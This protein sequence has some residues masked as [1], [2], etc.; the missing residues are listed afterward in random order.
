MTNIVKPKTYVFGIPRMSN[1][2]LWITQMKL[3]L[4]AVRRFSAI[5]VTGACLLMNSSESS[6]QPAGY[7]YDE[8]KVPA[9]EL[10]EIL[11]AN[12]GSAITDADVWKSVRRPEILELFAE[13]VFGTLPPDVPQLRTRLRSRTDAAIEGT[14]VRR[15]ITVYFS[16]D[17][18]GPQMDILVYTPANADGPVPCFLGLNFNGNQT[19]EDDPAIRLTTSWIRADRNKTG[20]PNVASEDSRGKSSS[21]WP[22]KDIVARGY[23][24]A[25]VYCGDIDPDFD[26]GFKN[27]IHSLW[28]ADQQGDRAG[29]AGGTIS[30]WSW[31]LSRALDI[32]ETDPLVDGTRVAV[33]GHSRLGKT[34]LWAGATDER[35]KLVISNNS[36]C[37]G[38][39][40][41]RRRFGETVKRI[42][43]SFPHWFCRNHRQ[44]NDNEDQLPVDHHMLMALVAPRAVYVAS[45]E[46]DTWADPKG[47]MLSLYHAGEV[48]RLFEQAALPSDQMPEVNQPIHTDVGYHIRS[49]KHDVTAYDW[50]QYLD[51][52]D[53]HLK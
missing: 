4:P 3:S 45:A 40:L 25:T 7:N 19:I 14:A 24:L 12:D 23:G 28:A 34:S 36:G 32:L 53:I 15:E 48:Y 22:V 10:P 50:S 13:H 51:F 49:G 16:D 20:N 11:V 39:A 6:A 30:A 42:N 18:N 47:E 17:D 44:Y 38:A 33:I 52:A 46:D 35:F 2:V 37:G 43:T 26:D 1:T 41:S 21:R 9:Y 29:N 8:S 27:G 31:G 5:A